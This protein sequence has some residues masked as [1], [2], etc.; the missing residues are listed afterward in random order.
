MLDDACQSVALAGSS[1]AIQRI[2]AVL[3]RLAPSG[4]NVLLQGEPGSGK[5]Q[6]AAVL[7]ARASGGGTPLPIVPIVPLGG[8]DDGEIEQNLF[9][10]IAIRQLSSGADC[11][12]VYLEAIETLAPRLQRRLAAAL[13]R[14]DVRPAR[15][16]AGSVLGLDEQVRLGLFCPT[17]RRQLG[18]VEIRLPALRDRC[19]DISTMIDMCLRRWAQRNGRPPI[20]STAAIAV[21]TRYDWPGNVP[22]LER[23]I[24]AACAIAGGW[25]LGPEPIRRLLRSLPPAH[26]QP[27]L[28]LA[29]PSGA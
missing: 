22:E 14:D 17:L 9:D 15:I 11:G 7:H 29:A 24:E 6:C 13:A 12:A 26:A 4:A 1:T 3:D 28:V 19:E 18:V 10:A 21:L 16:I 23:I 2:R 8:L 20:F 27:H 5:L 25:F